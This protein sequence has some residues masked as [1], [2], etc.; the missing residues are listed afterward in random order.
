VT[1]QRTRRGSDSQPLK[2]E[3]IQARSKAK[4]TSEVDRRWAALMGL[5]DAEVA[6]LLARRERPL[7]DAEAEELA[8]GW[9]VVELYDCRWLKSTFDFPV[10]EAASL[11][12][13]YLFATIQMTSWPIALNLGMDGEGRV[14]VALTDAGARAGNLSGGVVFFARLLSSG[15]RINSERTRATRPDRAQLGD[16]R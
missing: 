16:S 11:F 14:Q 8:P 2:P 7:T 12:T 15:F 1:K 5:D 4:K 10:L 9:A 3:R 6:R 13:N